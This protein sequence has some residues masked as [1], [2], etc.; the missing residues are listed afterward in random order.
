[1]L[2]VV[3]L[4]LALWIPA[5]SIQT[6]ALSAGYDL[7][8]WTVDGGGGSVSDEAS[9]Y[10]L[11]STLGQPD[12]VGWEGSRYTLTGGFWSGALVAYGTYLPLV[13]RDF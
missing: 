3:S 8:W 1:M 9:S 2:I 13:L 11:G 7:S 4:V 12:A 6:R 10:A 5:S